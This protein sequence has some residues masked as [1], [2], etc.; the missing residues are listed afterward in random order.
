MPILITGAAG[1]IGSHLAEELVKR[2]EKVIGI[3]CL[4][5]GR[6]ENLSTI[7]NNPEFTYINDNISNA[8]LMDDLI[9]SCHTIYHL[10]ASVGVKL[11]T[12]NPLESIKNNIESTLGLFETSNKYNRKVFFASSSE[13]Y[14]KANSGLL[15]EDDDLTLGPTHILRWGYGCSKA[16]GEYVGLSYYRQHKLPIVIGRFFNICG[17]RQVGSYGMVI[18]RFVRAALRG[19][20][21]TV[22]GTGSQVRSFTYITD[23]VNATIGLMNTPG[24]EG[25]VFNIGNSRPISIM[26]LARMV[27]KI[28]NSNSSIKIVPYQEAYNAD[29]EDMPYRVPDTSKLEKAIM[30]TPRVNLESMLEHIIHYWK[31]KA[32]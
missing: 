21:I 22:Y 20:P 13:V 32:S 14:G 23:A 31:D 16:I 12:N 7:I 25:E 4:S 27:K 2:G 15:C 29:F 19:E 30:I 3:D 6:T 24:T 1:F 28:T 8:A 10:A 5:T 11:L 26:E 18:P 9:S 17:P